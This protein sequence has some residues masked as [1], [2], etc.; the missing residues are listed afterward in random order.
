MG[1]EQGSTGQEVSPACMHEDSVIKARQYAGYQTP[2]IQEQS[3]VTC[4]NY[5]LVK[6]IEESAINCDIEQSIK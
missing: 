6:R 4:R 2:A 5:Q 3:L 1:G